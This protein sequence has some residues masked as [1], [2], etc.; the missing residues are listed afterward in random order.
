MD[1]HL[2]IIT[3]EKTLYSA[4]VGFIQLPGVDGSFTVLKGHAP[5]V[6]ILTKGKVRVIGKDGK[7]SFFE[8]SEGVFECNNNSATVLMGRE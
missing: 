5:I 2:K 6:S 7:E 8:C 3:P 1:L 4:D